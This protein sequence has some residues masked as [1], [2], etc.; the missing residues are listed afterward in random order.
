MGQTTDEIVAVRTNTSGPL[1]AGDSFPQ[2]TWVRW[3]NYGY[4]TFSGYKRVYFAIPAT[5]SGTLGANYN[6]S[7][8]NYDVLQRVVREQ[9]AGG[10]ISRSVFQMM[11][12]KL[13]AWVG[14]DDTGASDTN[15]AGAGGSNNMKQVEGYQFD[16]GSAGGDGNLTL[17]TRYENDTS[18]RQTL[19]GYDWRNRQ[20]SQ[21]GEIDF[22]ESYTYDNL[23]RQIQVQ[24][25]DTS[26]SGALVSLAQT[27]YDHMGRVYRTKQYSSQG[28]SGPVLQSD[29]WFDATGNAIKQAPS[30]SRILTKTLYDGVNRPTRRY[31]SYN[32]TE[33]GYN[34]P[35]TVTND[36]VMSQTETTYDAASNVIQQITRERFHNATGTGALT[37]PSGAQ[38][39]ARVSY[40]ASFPD[41]LGRNQAV[42]SYGTNGGTA[43][44]WPTTVPARS[45][46][47]LVTTTSYNNDGEAYSIIDPNAIEQRKT[48]DDA[49]RLTQIVDNYTGGTPSGD[50][51]RTTQFTYNPD[52]QVLT[53]TDKNGTTGDQVTQ[54]VYGTTLAGSD[55]ASK[56]LLTTVIYPDSVGGSDQVVL[57]YNRLGEAKTNTDQR[58]TVHTLI[59][60][61]LG[62]FSQDQ[63][64]TL[65]TGVDNGILMIARTYDVRGNPLNVTSYNAVSGGS[66]VNDVQSAYNSFGQLTA[67]YQ[68]HSGAVNTATTPKVQYAYASG[69]ANTVRPVSLTYPNGRVINL[70]YG[71]ANATNDVLSRIAGLV[72]S[73]GPA[74]HLADYTYLGLGTVV[75]AASPQPGSQLTYI[76]QTGDTHANTDG[77]DQYT[78]FDRFGRVIDQYW[79]KPGTGAL[80][81]IQYGFDRASNRQWRDNLVAGSNYQDEYYNYDGLNQ[82]QM[83][84]RG[85]LNSGR[86]GISGTPTWEED[87]TFDPTGN[88]G[89]YTTKTGGST[90]LNQN[91]THNKVNELATLSGSGSLLGFD[92]AGNMT[93][94]PQ[95]GSWS[96]AYTLVW[97]AWNRLVSVANGGTNVATYA[98]DGLM[99]RA[100]KATSGSTRHFYYS[101]QWQIL[102]ERIGSATSAQRHF[103]WGLR[104][105][106]DLVL[107]DR[108]TTDGGTLN[109][110]FYALHDYF[111]PTAVVDTSG[112]VQERYGYD[113]YGASRVMAA[114]FSLRA[115]SSYGWETRFAAYR[116]DSESGLYLA[117]N[118]FSHPLLGRWLSR[119]PI[120][121][122]AGINLYAYCLNNSINYTDPEGLDITDWDWIEPAANFSA[123]VA[124]SLTMGITSWLRRKMD[125]DQV[126]Y[127]SGLYYVGEATEFVV[128]T[129]VTLGGGALRKKATQY[130]GKAGR[131]LLEKNARKGFRKAIGGVTGAVVGGI[132]HHWNPIRQGRFPL[133]Y[134]WAARGFWNMTWLRS[135]LFLTA[136]QTHR[137]LH[138]YLKMLDALDI[139]RAWSSPIRSAGNAIIQFIN[140][141]GVKQNEMGNCPLAPDLDI[142]VDYSVMLNAYNEAYTDIPEGPDHFK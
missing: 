78:G 20:T 85:Q 97:D 14:T 11:G 15:P 112:A 33:S 58:G 93:T 108:D 36:T 125:I 56:A 40:A 22:Y 52:D 26:S 100:T 55:V 91:R 46:T 27:F 114:D 121:E 18:T 54:Y 38:P 124:D 117:R 37:T 69:S 50:T 25:N 64:T 119:D 120:G 110:R 63:V 113:A 98:Y 57:T 138:W 7:T 101:A 70:S 43:P 28:T 142:E 17:L 128:E 53:R 82:L 115:T 2:S 42:V 122:A 1:S 75:V 16:G 109:E 76:Q 12:W 49:G 68:S 141:L 65:G 89:N 60:D 62:R 73:D 92:A 86:T 116:W 99:R 23:D 72:D 83:L 5:G 45:N 132:I 47:V 131:Y 80:E 139:A 24:R 90:S 71:T 66:V 107:R 135:G 130:A 105:S 123:G 8:Y 137:F 79:L 118:R 48:F 6:Q 77:G 44:T 140:N 32:L 9:S 59:Y 3:T 129:T 4:A 31:V 21:D 106:D 127:S 61:K 96:S 87:F 95:P 35:I 29:F 134:K 84:T 41:P 51:D 10:T 88:W 104:Y 133:P 136:G 111:N 94:A 39:Q 19:Y 74:T 126:D 81:R 102:E 30:G 34:D 13:S 67:E 103:V